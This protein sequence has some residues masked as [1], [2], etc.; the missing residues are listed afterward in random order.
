MPTLRSLPLVLL[1]LAPAA[2]QSQGVADS[3]RAIDARWAAS[4]AQ[5]D[6]AL[7][8][9]LMAPD[10]VAT[11]TNG[12]TK[13]RATELADVRANPGLTVH[14]FRSADVR[15]RAYGNAAVVTG[16]LEWSMTYNGRASEV[17]RR[18]TATWVRGGAHGWQLVSLHVGNAP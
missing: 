5:H 2:V 10:F 3:V 8:L 15:V 18:Y 1:L 14:Y 6:T 4:Y 7:A 9:G 12:S 17:R 16:R 13:D 11:A